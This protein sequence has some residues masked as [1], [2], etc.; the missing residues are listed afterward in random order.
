LNKIFE[1]EFNHLVFSTIKDFTE[2]VRVLLGGL[3][4]STKAMNAFI[5]DKLKEYEREKT[6]EYLDYDIQLADENNDCLVN[7]QYHI[8]SNSKSE[9]N[10]S[11]TRLGKHLLDTR[12]PVFHNIDDY[13]QYDIV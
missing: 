8:P 9:T 11:L 1:Q 2:E 4:I 7:L 13:D 6:P 5:R 3:G 12:T 10:T